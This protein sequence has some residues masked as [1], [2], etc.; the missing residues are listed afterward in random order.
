MTS[1]AM[2]SRWVDAKL[3]RI[4]D[5]SLARDR[6]RMPA[7]RTSAFTVSPARVLEGVAEEI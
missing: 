4:D 6:Y 3:K 1:D 7:S 2:C 5:L